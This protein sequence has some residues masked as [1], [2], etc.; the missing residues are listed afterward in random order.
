MV[1]KKI[2]VNW[3]DLK[4][5]KKAERLKLNLENRGYNYVK[6]IREGLNKNLIIYEK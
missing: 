3:E 5:I 4:S 6:T 1:L 2:I